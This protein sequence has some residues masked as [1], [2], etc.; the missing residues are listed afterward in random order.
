MDELKTLLNA[1][2]ATLEGKVLK[3]LK[4][5][6][7]EFA[8]ML[9]KFKQ[10]EEPAQLICATAFVRNTVVIVKRCDEWFGTKYDTKKFRSADLAIARWGLKYGGKYEAYATWTPKDWFPGN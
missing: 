9:K 10:M 4:P 3:L 6:I 7:M 5:V 2:Y 8:P 1:L